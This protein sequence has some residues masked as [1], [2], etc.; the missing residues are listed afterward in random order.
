MLP[1]CCSPPRAPRLH[2]ALGQTQI[3]LPPSAPRSRVPPLSELPRNLLPPAP[4]EYSS[5]R[6]KPALAG[7][8]ALLRPPASPAPSL[9]SVSNSPAALRVHRIF[10]LP[11]PAL[12][13]NPRCRRL[14]ST[15][16]SRT[17]L[18]LLRPLPRYPN[19]DPPIPG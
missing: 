4:P 7:F 11:L 3:P 5:A 18:P 17:L 1:P 13:Q 15:R 12:P 16:P 2:S 6:C 8:P 19:P 14:A 10:P 9:A